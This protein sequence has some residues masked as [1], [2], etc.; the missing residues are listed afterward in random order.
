MPS[1]KVIAATLA[2]VLA[3]IAT[4]LNDDGLPASAADWGRLAAK[5]ITAAVATFGAGWSVADRTIA[6]SSRAVALGQ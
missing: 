3:A 5:A 6:P 1:T 4:S 2:A